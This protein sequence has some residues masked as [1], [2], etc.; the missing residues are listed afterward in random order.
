MDLFFWIW[1]RIT[2]F[3]D[4]VD[5]DSR[6]TCPSCSSRI[7]SLLHDKHS[8]CVACRGVECTFDKRCEECSSWGDVFMLKYVKHMKALA[9]KSSSCEAKKPL[10]VKPS[11]ARLRS[12]AGD[13]GA[14]PSG[15]A[16]SGS[17][18][19]VT[20]TEVE[21]LISASSVNYLVLL[22]PPWRVLLL[23]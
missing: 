6:W 2:H 8:V 7:S 12:S 13:S 3:L 18:A 9:S 4:P 19:G 23:I 22:L 20:E 5:L 14:T 17:I 15:S 11:G 16:V 10:E 1:P 21:E